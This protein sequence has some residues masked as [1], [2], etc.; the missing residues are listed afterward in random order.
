MCEFCCSF[1]VERSVLVMV[2]RIENVLARRNKLE[3]SLLAP[4]AKRQALI[5]SL[6][7]DAVLWS[8]VKATQIFW[9]ASSIYESRE[10]YTTTDDAR[11][12]CLIRKKSSLLFDVFLFF[13]F[14]FFLRHDRRIRIIV[15]P[16]RISCLY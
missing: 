2:R 16:T 9:Q 5:S 10:G 13:F 4:D 11:H 6:R 3:R 8:V 7:R 15:L 14:F 1:C 12:R